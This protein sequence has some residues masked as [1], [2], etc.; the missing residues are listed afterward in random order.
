MSLSDRGVSFSDRHVTLSDR[1][2]CLSDR[3]ISLRQTYVSL[4]QTYV[5]LRQTYAISDT[6]IPPRSIISA[7]NQVP[8]A[9]LG[10]ILSQDG[11]TASGNLVKR[12]PGPFPPVW[13]PKIAKNIK[14][15]NS[16][17]KAKQT[18]DLP[19]S[20]AAMLLIEGRR[21]LHLMEIAQH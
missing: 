7:M 5:S 12:L 4:R 18:P 10:P 8:V 13:A 14:H 21:R 19:L 20:A 9:R 1:H 17:Q 15:R 11:A 3:H 6:S 2:A 16:G